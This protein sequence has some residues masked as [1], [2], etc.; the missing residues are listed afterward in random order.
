MNIG[1]VSSNKTKKRQS[2]S[3]HVDK[4]NLNGNVIS[5]HNLTKQAKLGYDSLKTTPLTDILKIKSQ[6]SIDYGLSANKKGQGSP[7]IGLTNMV[8][9]SS[10]GDR[11]K[12]TLTPKSIKDLLEEKK[13]KLSFSPSQGSQGDSSRYTNS[14]KISVPMRIEDI[15]TLRHK[16]NQIIGQ[17]RSHDSSN[18]PNKASGSP[19]NNHQSTKLSPPGSPTSNIPPSSLLKTPT[20]SSKSRPYECVYRKG[21]LVT[22]CCINHQDKK[23][24]YYVV[25]NYRVVQI[26]GQRDY[27]RGVCS[28]CAVRLANSGYQIEEIESDEEEESKLNE[29]NLFITRVMNMRKLNRLALK[30]AEKKQKELIDHY[31]RESVE[32]ESLS[33]AVEDICEFMREGLVQV[34]ECLEKDAEREN[35][36]FTDI[37]DILND[38]DKEIKVFADNLNENFED[39]INTLDLTTLRGNIVKF[40]DHLKNF[41]SSSKKSLDTCL[42]VL[43]L[44]KI[45]DK[46]MR[47]VKNVTKKLFRAKQEVVGLKDCTQILEEVEVLLNELG[48]ADPFMSPPSCLK[49]H[50]NNVFISFDANSG[51]Q[52]GRNHPVINTKHTE[53]E[54]FSMLDKID[55]SHID[56]LSLYTSGEPLFILSPTEAD[57]ASKQTPE[58]GQKEIPPA[59]LQE[60]LFSLRKNYNDNNRDNERNDRQKDS[61]KKKPTSSKQ[62]QNN[63]YTPFSERADLSHHSD[64]DDLF[65]FIGKKKEEKHNAD[66]ENSNSSFLNKQ[67][68]NSKCKKVLFSEDNN[69]GKLDNNDYGNPNHNEEDD[70]A[71]DEQLLERQT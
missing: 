27:Q 56:D 40:D 49:Q 43:S 41:E 61:F 18:Y 16:K 68:V 20:T 70:P 65:N 31:R 62:S 45:D 38:N 52:A 42:S 66:H 35:S 71:L 60:Y 7:V 2:D 55:D 64:T 51:T 54:Y 69:E 48:K 22:L 32:L 6:Q 21:M 30:D 63:Q 24:K 9:N 53:D 12:R 44:A 67:S 33:R 59:H 11:R 57:F 50:S 14:Q 25:Q 28:K 29:F 26:D 47:D 13:K 23:S 19:H 17:N 37:I 5:I 39:T 3:M 10:S 8:D 15:L 4:E 36:K 58:L 46:V 34:K 1:D